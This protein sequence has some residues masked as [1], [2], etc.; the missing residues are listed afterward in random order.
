MTWVT[1]FIIA[2][3]IG[4]GANLDNISLGM[5][6]GIAKTKIPHW[7]NTIINFFGF[8]TALLGAYLG[9]ILSRYISQNIAELVS[10]MILSGIGLFIL[11]TTYV[12]PRISK[13]TSQHTLQ[14]PGFKQAI[15][16]GIGLSFSNVAS[17]FSATISNSA[18]LWTT[19]FSIS[20]WGYIMVFLGNIIGIGIV[21]RFLGKYSSLVSGL[22]LISV[23]VIQI[24]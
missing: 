20:A 4:I 9:E 23:G 6:Y 21:S 13:E 1:G 16:L 19:V 7:V 11:Y 12:H 2:N 17:S 15:L 8:F 10:C 24:T 3:L 22:L 18:S 5:A 14:K